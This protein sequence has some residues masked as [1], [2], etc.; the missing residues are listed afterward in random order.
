LKLFLDNPHLS[1]YI[2]IV[3]ALFLLFGATF[4]I[5]KIGAARKPIGI[6]LI[7]VPVIYFYIILDAHLINIPFTDDFNLLE[8]VD[9]FRNAPDFLSAIKAL[10]EQVNQHRFAFERIVMLVM[11]FFTGTVNIKSQIILGDLFLLGILYMLFRAF[12]KE[13]VS[14]YYFIPVPYVLFSL[15]YWENAYWGIAALQNTPLIFFAFVTA[16]ALG[17]GDNRGFYLGILAALLT[18]FTS[19]SGLLTWIIG[20]IILSFQKRF[21][22]L[23]FWLLAAIAVVLFYFLFDYQ[24]IPAN[25]DKV[26][27]HPVY[28][29]IFALGFWGNGLYLD[30]RHPL[31]PKFHA[32]LIA[33]VLLGGAIFLLFLA[34]FVRILMKR[35]LVWSD[36]FLWGAMMFSMGTG[37][38]FVISRPINTYLMYGGNV[39]SRRYM[40]FGIAL[41]ATAY[42][43][44]VILVKSK[45]QLRD[46]AVITVGSG[47]VIL[48]FVSYYLSIVQ[49]R[50]MHDDVVIDGYFWKNYN[51]FLTAGDRFGDIPFWNHPTRMKNLVNSLEASGLTDLYQFNGIPA[52]KVLVAETLDKN[53]VYNGSFDAAFHRRNSDSNIPSRYYRFTAAPNAGLPVPSYFVLASAKYTI[54]LPAVPV[55]NPFAEM[56]KSGA[57]YSNTYQYSLFKS[58]LPEGIYDVLILYA[59]QS[60]PVGWKS[61]PTGKRV[62]ID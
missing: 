3:A 8:T 16:Y 43:C 60:A 1:V 57:Y 42:V 11:V 49:V 52:H 58:K 54:V 18:T 6:I 23:A 15:M 30:V 40:I 7:F 20:I 48:N 5:P 33:C 14:F 35:K 17:R 25:G 46:I 41:L 2:G 10:F 36:W 56:L 45:K 13:E 55:P 51:T 53:A 59:D 24:V 47:F 34:W 50:K 12:K 19:G 31:V 32:D 22:L 29:F 39:F 28:N 26:W 37:A 9:K 4:A 38:M 27:T 44:L 21:R 61:V 62:K